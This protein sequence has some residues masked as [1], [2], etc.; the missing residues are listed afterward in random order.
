MDTSI[1]V[2]VVPT[3]AL[4]DRRIN[5]SVLPKIAAQKADS[6]FRHRLQSGDLL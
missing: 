5:H 3:E 2:P 6:L 4:R 1:R